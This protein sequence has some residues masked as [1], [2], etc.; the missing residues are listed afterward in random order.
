MNATNFRVQVRRPLIL[1]GF[2]VILIFLQSS[3]TFSK[4]DVTN[5]LQWRSIFSL[6]TEKHAD[7]GTAAIPADTHVE[8]FSA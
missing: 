2:K 8:F 5:C 7:K 3:R 4:Q 6:W 1:S